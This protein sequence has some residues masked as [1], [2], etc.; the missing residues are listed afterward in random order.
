LNGVLYS[1]YSHSSSQL[2]SQ[3]CYLLH[4]S[5]NEVAKLVESLGDFSGIK[6][7]AKKAKQIGL[8]FS[9]CHAL[10]EVPDGTYKVIDDIKLLGYNFTDGCRLVRAK[11]ARVLSQKLLIISWNTRYHPAVY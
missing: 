6:T 7:I 2:R 3:A 8:L 11:T 5:K 9:S 1:F 4:G 10:M